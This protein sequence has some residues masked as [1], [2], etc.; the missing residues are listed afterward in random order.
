MH[1]P[2]CL[3]VVAAASVLAALTTVSPVQPVESLAASRQGSDLLVRSSGWQATIDI[4]S[5]RIRSFLLDGMELTRLEASGRGGWAA[6]PASHRPEFSLVD[7]RTTPVDLDVLLAA[8]GPDLRV[9]RRFTFRPDRPWVRVDTTWENLSPFAMS[10]PSSPTVTNLALP[11]GV[12]R[13]TEIYSIDR[14]NGAEVLSPELFV[15]RL[16]SDPTAR[17]LRWAAVTDPA[18]RVAV[19]F[20]LDQPGARLVPPRRSSDGTLTLGWR[21]PCVP[22]GHTLTTS[23]TVLPLRGLAAISELNGHFAADSSPRNAN[24]RVRSRL[25]IMPLGD[26]LRE[27]SVVSRTYDADGREM[28]LC[29]PLLL[30]AA[31]P[32]SATGG[33]VIG[34]S[35]RS[36]V[37]WIEH[38]V[39]AQG[40]SLGKF[41]VPTEAHLRA[42]PPHLAREGVLPPAPRPIPMQGSAAGMTP[43]DVRRTGGKLELWQFDRP[44]RPESL[45]DLDLTVRAGSARTVYLGISSPSP[46]ADLTLALQRNGP[47]QPPASPVP[48]AAV[49]FWRLNEDDGPAMLEPFTSASLDPGQTAWCAVTADAGS[50][51]A[52]TY[53]GRVM[54]GSG[55]ERQE[56][57]LVL[58]VVGRP[59]P[60]PRAFGLW[61]LGSA[62]GAPSSGAALSRLCEFGVDGVTLPASCPDELRWNAEQL[63]FSILA[64]SSAGGTGAPGPAAPQRTATALPWPLWIVQGDALPS[65]AQQLAARAGY[66]PA[67]VCTDLDSAAQSVPRRP[68][69]RFLL[70][71][72]G[73]P[74]GA[75]TRLLA[76]GMLGAGEPVWLCLDIEGIDWRRAALELRSLLWAAAWQGLA[77]VAVLCEAPE[78]AAGRQWAIWHILRDACDEVAMWR[79]ARSACRRLGQGSD[80]SPAT[81]AVLAREELER[82]VGPSDHCLLRVRQQSSGPP[83]T[84]VAPE[85]GERCLRMAQFSRAWQATLRATPPGSPRVPPGTPCPLYWQ[86]VPLLEGERLLWAI[87]A[88]AGEQPWVAGRAL[89]EAIRNRSG[90]TVL[91][92]RSLPDL[93]EAG[94]F[95]LVW[96][97]DGESVLG[98]LPDAYRRVL[99][100]PGRR[101]VVVAQ[102]NG[103]PVVVL[104]AGQKHM[105]TVLHALRDEPDLYSP[106]RRVR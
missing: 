53:A 93:T 91:L 86:D 2:P 21:Y 14:G 23:F 65:A 85:N 69:R 59:A 25:E 76:S 84:E 3:C 97:L 30:S 92:Q 62:C 1:H 36:P 60:S 66:V 13:G 83:Y 46:V 38:E 47:D 44:G 42:R 58:R 17:A 24:G 50:L 6:D 22:A 37:A 52:G 10:G 64:F 99:T 95:R 49:Q 48:P 100:H 43:Q 67:V 96:L 90:R 5:A 106:A 75:A 8:D 74:E 12:A 88:P 61:Y 104:V 56:V 63:G 79:A 81:M 68:E 78:E 54:I 31:K 71:R 7:Q 87:T 70:V 26:A 34:T 80:G 57:R 27:V 9:T 105:G 94:P 55:A 15:A 18:K 77:G 11:G 73:C 41:T 89:Q 28:D 4:P 32:L 101:G 103:G 40:A 33:T 45:Q 29:A 20:R 98:S 19:A 16:Y 39:F 82:V 51:A 72:D 35:A 102:V